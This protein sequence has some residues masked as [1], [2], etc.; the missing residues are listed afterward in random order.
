MNKRD[1]NKKKKMNL[2]GSQTFGKA[3]KG[4]FTP[5]ALARLA[6]AFTACAVGL[7]SGSSSYAA[8]AG[9][10]FT[11]NVTVNNSCT[12]VVQND[13]RFGMSADLRQLSSKLAGGAP[14]VA[15]IVST[16]NYRIS[17][18]AVPNLTS[19]PTGG[20]TNVTMAARYSGQSISNGRTFTERP[21]ANRIRL[22][23]GLSTTRVTVHLAATRTGSAFP[24][25]YYQ[26]TVTLRCE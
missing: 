21:G 20:N 25:G 9:V 16:R 10:T 11:G 1:I 3:G 18:I 2:T 8:T 15:N 23:N 6:V 12:I 19:Y 7:Y 17:A 22:R 24:S 4:V 13:G 5:G 26:G 14:A